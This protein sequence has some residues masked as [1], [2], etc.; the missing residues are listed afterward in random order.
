[1]K[2]KP[3]RVGAHRHRVQLFA[4]RGERDEFGAYLETREL[5]A[6]FNCSVEHEEQD[7]SSSAANRSLERLAFITRYN[8]KLL[9]IVADQI[10]VFNGAEYTVEFCIDPD[11]KKRQLV[12]TASRTL[13]AE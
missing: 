4:L 2:V 9:P 5:K 11:F 10:I 12:I 13:G 3:I 1:M 6:T 8:P 7:E